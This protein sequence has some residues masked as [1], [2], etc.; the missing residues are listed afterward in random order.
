MQEKPQFPH[1]PTQGWALSPISPW[2]QPSGCAT[3]PTCTPN[4]R[5]L[6]GI[7]L[8]L[9]GETKNKKQA[10]AEGVRGSRWE[11]QSSRSGWDGRQT[12]Q[13]QGLGAA[14]SL[15]S[16]NH[17]HRCLALTAWQD[18][19][20]HRGAVWL[21]PYLFPSQIPG[22][23]C[24]C[25]TPNIRRAL[26]SRI[27]MCLLTPVMIFQNTWATNCYHALWVFTVIR[28]LKQTQPFLMILYLLTDSLACVYLNSCWG[29]FL[30][31]STL[32]KHKK[33]LKKTQPYLQISDTF[34][35]FCLHFYGCHMAQISLLNFHCMKE[36]WFKTFW[37]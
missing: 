14:R 3:C 19:S 33:K 20:L 8:S 18:P 29:F 6:L 1:H 4:L 36:K 13:N 23:Q 28:V 30:K 26:W 34:E 12:E 27:L 25:D 7:R 15:P 31:Y 9:A 2:G 17:P 11:S 22:L 10:L 32:L 35:R 5:F 16:N 37:F 21:L 24:L